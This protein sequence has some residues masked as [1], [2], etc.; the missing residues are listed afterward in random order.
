MEW[1]VCLRQQALDSQKGAQ[2]MPAV[3]TLHMESQPAFTH[4]LK[5][6]E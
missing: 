1:E 3:I 4:L 2:G 5:M 6:S